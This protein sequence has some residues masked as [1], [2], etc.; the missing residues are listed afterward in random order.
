MNA[1]SRLRD[2]RAHFQALSPR[3][4]AFLWYAPVVLVAAVLRLVNL[5]SPKTL[6]FDEV[7]YVRDA[8]S[9]WNLGYEAEWVAGGDF[10]AGAVN[11]FTRVGDFI[12]HPPLGKW[13]IGAGIALFGPENPFGWRIATALAGIGVVVLVLFI[14]KRLFGSHA[15]AALAG[16]L[17]AIDGIA[18]VMSRT[19]LLDGILALFVLAAFLAILRHLDTPGW[20][21]WLLLAGVLVGAGIAVKWSGLFALAAFGIWVVV[22]ETIRR[23]KARRGKPFIGRALLDAI[24]TFTLFVPVAVVVYLS[25]WAGWILS[26]DAYNRRWASDSGYGDGI[27]G[28]ARGLWKYH[29]DIYDYNIGLDTPHNYQANPLSWLVLYRPTAFY[30]QETEITG[31]VQ[32]ITSIANPMVWW[33][34]VA[35]LFFLIVRLFRRMTWQN[36]AILVGVGATYLPW[37]VFSGRT[38]FQF[39]TVTLEPFLVLALVSALVWMWNHQLR[40]VVVNYL[41]V[42]VAVSAFFVPVWLGI[43]IPYWFAVLHYWFP[44]WI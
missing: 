27:Y 17:V 42:V 13:L 4:Q 6:V 35:A 25:S 19:A 31:V 36:A 16:A 29:R 34:G 8:W 3:V 11:S 22:V 20:G 2:I 41:V 9:M 7:Y 33:G 37:L 24:R 26:S 40:T 30:Y 14:A 43:P 38:V 1:S 10:A 28:I 18:I 12:A 15:V 39:Y 44:G 23:R 32:Y 5:G 21:G